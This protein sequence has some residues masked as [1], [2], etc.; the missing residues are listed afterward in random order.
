MTTGE[1]IKTLR[2]KLKMNQTEF[3]KEIQVS[4]TTVC[5]LE[6]GRYNI[7]R[8][9]KHILCQRF[10]V[11]PVWLDTGEGEMYLEL[12][13]AEAIAPTIIDILNNNENLLETVREA[14]HFFDDTDWK[15]ANAF[16][17]FLKG[18]NEIVERNE[19]EA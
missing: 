17:E 9:T 6:T 1:R 16:L 11:N 4:T 5:Q 3:A 15:K 8:T 12:N 13:T 19:E 18:K 7:A 2:K 14:I 10:N